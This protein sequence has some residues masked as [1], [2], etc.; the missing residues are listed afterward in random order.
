MPKFKVGDKF[1]LKKDVPESIFEIV[2]IESNKYELILLQ[3]WNGYSKHLRWYDNINHIDENFYTRRV[4]N[5]KNHLPK[6][7]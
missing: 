2:S 4:L 3:S 7:W 5:H 6:W 1:Y